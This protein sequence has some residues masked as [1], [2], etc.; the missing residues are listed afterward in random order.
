M[1][2]EWMDLL[3]KIDPDTVFSANMNL[4]FLDSQKDT[5]F[6]IV[7]VAPNTGVYTC[8]SVGMKLN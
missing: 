2:F 6:D 7:S 1:Y 5:P 3:Q 4:L 8:P